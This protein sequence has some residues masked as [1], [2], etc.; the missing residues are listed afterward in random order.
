LIKKNRKIIL[1][2]YKINIDDIY[3]E[4]YNLDILHDI[5]T[6]IENKT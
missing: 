5:K 6:F 1:E 4:T 2:K 3:P